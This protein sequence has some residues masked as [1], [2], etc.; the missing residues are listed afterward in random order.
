MEPRPTIQS[1]NRKKVRFFSSVSKRR[2]APDGNPLPSEAPSALQAP[3]LD[4]A[5]PSE[6]TSATTGYNRILDELRGL[7]P[8][9]V[10]D[11]TESKEEAEPGDCAF[12]EDS[13]GQG[14][15]QLRRGKIRMQAQR[16]LDEMAAQYGDLLLGRIEQLTQA[17]NYSGEYS[18]N[19]DTAARGADLRTRLAGVKRQLDEEEVCYELLSR[20]CKRGRTFVDE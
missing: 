6:P 1:S 17:W 18:E 5:P 12:T 3:S 10:S 9:S 19:V 16:A 14:A 7:K 4:Q 13:P 11:Q 15:R 2:V 20:T 8:A